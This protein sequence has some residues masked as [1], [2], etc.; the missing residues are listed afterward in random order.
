M[1]KLNINCEE[2]FEDLVKPSVQILSKAE[3]QNQM[4]LLEIRSS[5]NNNYIQ[6]YN[7]LHL[8]IS[9]TQ[10]FCLIPTCSKISSHASIILTFSLNRIC[11]PFLFYTF[12]GC[13]DIIYDKNSKLYRSN[14]SKIPL[15]CFSK[16]DNC[17]YFGL[18]IPDLTITWP[19]IEST[20]A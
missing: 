16:F 6:V 15:L 13:H 14:W 12:P 2:L 10:L 17:V 18:E 19:T 4:L 1:Q 11:E 8:W 5:F 7:I 3:S 20:F 9:L